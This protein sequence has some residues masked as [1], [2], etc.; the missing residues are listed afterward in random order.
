MS[1]FHF[2]CSGF[3]YSEERGGKDQNVTFVDAARFTLF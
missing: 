1:G 3:D 2:I